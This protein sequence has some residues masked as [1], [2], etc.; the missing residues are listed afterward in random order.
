MIDDKI[1]GQSSNKVMT[2]YGNLSFIK[3]RL[4]IVLIV[5]HFKQQFKYNFYENFFSPHYN[6]QTLNLSS[7]N[8]SRY[9][10]TKNFRQIIKVGQS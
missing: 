5:N 3:D 9:M 4:M 6:I 2:L 8:R 7:C 10:Y 1:S